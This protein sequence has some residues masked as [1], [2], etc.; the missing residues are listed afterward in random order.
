MVRKTLFALTAAVALGAAALAPTSAS[1]WGS[2][3]GW[4][5]GGWGQWRMGPALR[6]P[7]LRVLWRR[8][9]RLLAQSVGRDPLWSGSAAGE[10]V[11]LNPAAWM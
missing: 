7:A 3:G 1:A 10:C 2:H 9:R 11:L 8:L 4:G 5:H 6:R